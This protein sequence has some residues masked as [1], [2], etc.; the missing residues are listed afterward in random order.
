MM[1]RPSVRAGG[2]S[3]RGLVEGARDGHSLQRGSECTGPGHCGDPTRIHPRTQL[4]SGAPGRGVRGPMSRRRRAGAR[5]QH[6]SAPSWAWSAVQARPD[7]EGSGPVWWWPPGWGLFTPCSRGGTPVGGMRRGRYLDPKF[8]QGAPITSM[9]WR[10]QGATEGPGP[11]QGWDHIHMHMGRA[12]PHISTHTCS[13]AHMQNMLTRPCV[14]L[15]E[16]HTCCLLGCRREG[17]CLWLH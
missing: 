13:Y 11:C 3:C 12:P 8:Q 1:L 16:A 5:V 14:Q 9:I 10:L 15:W 7:G 17:G 2:S 4:P 6:P